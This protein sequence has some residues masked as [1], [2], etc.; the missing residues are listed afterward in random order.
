MK[1][2][3]LISCLLLFPTTIY[4]CG[5]NEYE[6]CY[7]FCLIPNPLGGCAQEVK[8]CKCLP[9][10]G[11]DIGNAGEQAKD[12]VN[13]AAKEVGK[14]LENISKEAA[15]AVNNL[16]KTLEI[17]ANDIGANVSKSNEDVKAEIGRAGKDTEQA[18]S[19]V[20]RYMERMG[21][22][23]VP[24]L[25]QASIRVREG[26]VI[27][28]IWHLNV[29]PYQDGSKNAAL[30][31]TE[32]SVL[33]TVAQVAATAYGGPQGA[34]AYA[35]WLTYEQTGDAALAVKVG[36]LAGAANYAM[37]QAGKMPSTTEYEL[38]KKT[39][40]TG[41]IGGT[42]VAAAGGNESAVKE[43]FLKAG[44]MV[45]VQDTFKDM[46][47]HDL[48]GKASEGEP[49]CITVATVDCAPPSE[50]YVRNPDG[51]LALDD[52]GV[53]K[54]DVSRM[55][56]KRPMVGLKDPRATFSE[57]SVVMKGF[58]KVPGMNGMAVFH[59]QWAMKWDM[60]SFTT[61]T[62]IVPAVVLTYWGLGAPY[63]V[64][65][66][67][68]AVEAKQQDMAMLNRMI[69]PP[70]S[71][72]ESEKE[73]TGMSTVGNADKDGNPAVSLGV[74]QNDIVQSYLCSHGSM[75][76]VIAV[77]RSTM[78]D[79]GFACRVLYASE[80]SETAPWLAKNDGNYCGAKAAA[81]AKKQELFGFTCSQSAMNRVK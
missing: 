6:Q 69:A 23:A 34:A 30:A 68:T 72:S 11:G 49:Y 56:P 43:A 40:V 81:F 67:K 17:A 33:N 57:Q 55:D 12:S 77:E 25:E 70:P 75:A 14:G 9:K 4:A 28:A 71:N 16:A 48:S 29:A 64:G 47:T 59:D 1:K 41:A 80:K 37:A 22:S 65:L 62:S 50:S 61:P 3:A 58:S 26:K 18:V 15:I 60:N 79:R 32:S 76:R 51:S 10:V 8:D 21:Q 36:V 78:N 66:Q 53:P 19:A 2:G 52:R 24:A 42:A 20:G 54:F 13:N 73:N 38:M 74:R 7:S 31:M 63:Y 5:S 45:V 27:D 44:A 35:A 46:T 39:V